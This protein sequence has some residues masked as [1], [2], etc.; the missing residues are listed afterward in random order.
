MVHFCLFVGTPDGL[1]PLHDGDVIE[2]RL[3]N[4]T[5]IRFDSITVED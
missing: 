2:G 5:T 3:G 4:I 1:G